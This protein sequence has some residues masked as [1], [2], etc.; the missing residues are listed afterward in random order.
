MGCGS[1]RHQQGAVVTTKKVA[2]SANGKTDGSKKG[3]GKDVY[4]NK[5][6]ATSSSTPSQANSQLHQR[7]TRQIQDE[8]PPI[9]TNNKQTHEQRGQSSSQIGSHANA[10]NSQHHLAL[11]SHGD[12]NV[13]HNL[14]RPS[15]NDPIHSNNPHDA[16]GG[17]NKRASRSTAEMIPS[18]AAQPAPVAAKKSSTASLKKVTSVHGD[19]VP[20]ENKVSERQ[21]VKNASR[22]TLAKSSHSVNQN[23][24][25]KQNHEQETNDA[26]N[27]NQHEQ[28]QMPQIEMSSLQSTGNESK[29]NLSKSSKSL[30]WGQVND[31]WLIL[32]TSKT[33]RLCL[34]TNL[35]Q[36]NR[37]RKEDMKT[38]LRFAKAKTPC[39]KRANLQT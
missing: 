2:P 5:T 26:A 22:A 11:H 30:I 3:N 16:A 18:S 39:L 19:G 29:K 36:Q 7:P 31:I 13:D 35:I 21:D 33:F 32:T 25:Q 8:D 6:K 15:E 27:N 12:E 1:S 24:T 38:L 20:S 9:G 28:H 17:S 34:V 4:P 23:N 10:R 14:T 37:H